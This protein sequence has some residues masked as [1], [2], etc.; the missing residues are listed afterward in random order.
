MEG[1]S[2]VRPHEFDAA[3][4][5][6]AA[7]FSDA[8]AFLSRSLANVVA[9]LPELEPRQR[10]GELLHR[11][12]E[13]SVTVALGLKLVQ[14]TGHV[15]AGELLIRNGFLFEWDVIQR[16]LQDGT[17]DVTFL[18]VAEGVERRSCCEDT[19]SSFSTRTSV[20]TVRWATDQQ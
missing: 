5:A 14:L 4:A 19:W 12:P 8:L 7:A 11:F 10:G 13:K 1:L 3:A 18:V 17:E 9:L 2:T 6:A 20:E 16:T 15:R